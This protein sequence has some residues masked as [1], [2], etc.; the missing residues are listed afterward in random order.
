M[1][2]SEGGGRNLAPV[3]KVRQCIGRPGAGPGP[4][5]LR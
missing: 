3:V 2:I 4:N 1:P 5:R